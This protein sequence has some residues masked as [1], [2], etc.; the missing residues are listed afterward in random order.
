MTTGSVTVRNR[1]IAAAQRTYRRRRLLAALG[2]PTPDGPTQAPHGEQSDHRPVDGR[3][4][5]QHDQHDAAH[6]GAPRRHADAT[7][8]HHTGHCEVSGRCGDDRSAGRGCS[9]VLALRIAGMP[10]WVGPKAGRAWLTA[11]ELQNGRSRCSVDSLNLP[12]PAQAPA[13]SPLPTVGSPEAW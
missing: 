7:R 5:H 11:S 13:P 9:E 2:E 6:G 10:G 4:G 1:R 12:A 3:S 8:S